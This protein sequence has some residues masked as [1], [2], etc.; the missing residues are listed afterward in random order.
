ME[1]IVEKTGRLQGTV[2]APPSKALTHRAV[3]AASLSE[4]RSTIRD[5]STCAD[6][7]ATV[8]ACRMLGAKIERKGNVFCVDGNLKP[9]TPNNIV[10][11][12]ASGSTIRFIASICALADSVSILTGNKTLRRRPMQPLLDALNQVGA[13]CTS[14]KSDGTPPLVIFGGGIQGGKASLLGDVSSQFISSL[15]FATPKAKNETTIIL[16][17]SLES[18]PYVNMTLDVLR[19]HGIRMNYSSSHDRFTVPGEQEFRP[20]DHAVE[21]D[22]SSAAFLLAAAAL[23]KSRLKVTSLRKETSQGDKT[24]VGVIEKMGASVSVAEDY[25]VVDG[26]RSDLAGLEIDLRNAPD[27][28]PVCAVL[29][30]F[31]RGETTIIGVERLRF[32]ESD[33][34]AS[35][36]SELIKMG[37]KITHD[38]NS[39]VIEGKAK[40]QGA[41]LSSHNDHRIAMANTI[42]ALGAEGKTTVQG[43]QCVKKSYPDFLRDL[44]SVGGKIID[45]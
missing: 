41:K 28:I 27:L 16:T 43:V 26:N 31:A 40:L 4:G 21:G 38:K 7:L 34:I 25:V 37:A 10:Y 6:A 24:I 33:R 2:K 35:L 20:A 32:K 42:A 15:L 14:T 23:T 1:I 18:R 19:T 36:T 13:R 12:G 17:T 29:A 22:Y 8:R 39:L 45:G 3:I 44:R 11:C 9:N 5:P 30:C